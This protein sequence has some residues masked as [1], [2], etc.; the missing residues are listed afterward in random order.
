MK[1]FRGVSII[2]RY[3]QDGRQQETI[4]KPEFEDRISWVLFSVIVVLGVAIFGQM[5]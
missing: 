3:D 5:I 1:K 2:E 4:A